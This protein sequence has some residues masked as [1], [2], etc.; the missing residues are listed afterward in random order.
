MKLIRL[1]H[2]LVALLVPALS[3]VICGLVI[4]LFSRNL[5]LRVNLISKV[6]ALLGP[7]LA[8]LTL[9]CSG[10]EHL[11]QNR[12][13]IFIFN[14][15]SGL[16][17][18]IVC[19]LLK[20]DVVGVAKPALASNPVLGPLLKLTGTLFVDRGTG[21]KGTLPREDLML[22]A[23]ERL[24]EGY[25]IAIAPEGTRVHNHAVGRFKLGAFELAQRSGFPIVPI[26]IHNSGK[27]LAPKSTQLTPGTVNISVLPSSKVAKD[28]D[29]TAAATQMEQ[30]Y[31][32][33]LTAGY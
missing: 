25:S 13:A 10:S 29:L 26:V 17:P 8:G 4:S 1:V 9:H 12:P 2:L 18:V 5:R 31:E 23:V 15:Q 19:A 16:D 32:A 3:A 24:K 33:C 30:R 20:R 6:V 28:E 11:Q 7:N 22:A 27:R 21:E 14:H